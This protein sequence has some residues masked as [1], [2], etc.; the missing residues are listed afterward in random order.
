MRSICGLRGRYNYD[1]MG[2]VEPYSDRRYT[3][4]H[5]DYLYVQKKGVIPALQAEDIASCTTLNIVA[6]ENV[7]INAATFEVNAQNF[8]INANILFDSICVSD[9]YGCGQGG[10]LNLASENLVVQANNSIDVYA[11]EVYINS[12]VVIDG[13]L[14]V[15]DLYGCGPNETINIHGNVVLNINVVTTTLSSVGPGTSIVDQGLGPFLTVKSLQGAG[16]TV[17]SDEG[18]VINITSP[19]YTLVSL[20]SGVSMVAIPP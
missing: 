6:Q 18:D 2:R 16:A 15:T 19:N 8:F 12:N 14:C 20:G 10:S 4:L 3:T 17:V 13:S 7:I 9:V 5:T 11:P 1:P